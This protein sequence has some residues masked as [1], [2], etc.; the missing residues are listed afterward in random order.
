[1]CGWMLP[2]K[3]LCEGVSIQMGMCLLYCQMAQILVNVIGTPSG[4]DVRLEDK[5][6]KLCKCDGALD[7]L[8]IWEVGLPP[9]SWI[10]IKVDFLGGP[11]WGIALEWVY[12][13]INMSKLGEVS[14]N[15][16]RGYPKSKVDAY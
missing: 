10:L 4:Y 13:C 9:K 15:W 11:T 16:Q 6:R 3:S 7:M 12:K 14:P 5:L 1:M 8:K 2:L